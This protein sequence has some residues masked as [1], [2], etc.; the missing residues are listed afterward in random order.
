[1]I[2]CLMLCAMLLGLSSCNTLIGIGRDTKQ[3]FLWTKEKMEGHG[4][5]PSQG[6]YEPAPEAVYGDEDYGVPVY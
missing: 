2:K 3:A 1:M 4:N 5:P 6:G